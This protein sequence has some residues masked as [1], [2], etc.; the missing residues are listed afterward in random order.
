MEVILLEKV[1]NDLISPTSVRRDLSTAGV[2]DFILYDNYPNPFNPVT[3]IEYY[4]PKTNRR[5]VPVKLIVYDLLGQEITTL[6]DRYHKPG[7]YK[8]EFEAS[9][10]ASG[11]YIY[12]LRADD[13]VA[14]KPMILMK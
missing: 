4:I 2:D 9:G 1:G 3:M 13:F 5:I 14:R 6:V 8:I 10:L 7:K 11:N 12:E